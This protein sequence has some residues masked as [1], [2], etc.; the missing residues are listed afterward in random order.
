ML[1]YP[2][3]LCSFPVKRACAGFFLVMLTRFFRVV[4]M[5]T[6]TCGCVYVKSWSSEEEEDSGEGVEEDYDPDEEDFD[7]DQGTLVLL[8]NC[9]SREIGW[10][11][12]CSI[13]VGRPRWT[14]CPCCVKGKP[15]KSV[16]LPMMTAFTFVL[17][18]AEKAGGTLVRTYG[19]SRRG[20]LKGGSSHSTCTHKIQGVVVQRNVVWARKF[21]RI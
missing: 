2:P 14:I 8:V 7:L 15:W 16:S 3:P 19:P 10:T 18:K 20:D 9:G 5:C 21:N 13:L 6:F 4:C 17:L 12:N 1:V 11:S